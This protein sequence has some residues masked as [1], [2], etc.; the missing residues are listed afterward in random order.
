M[1]LRT[2]NM[3]SDK[4]FVLAK[5]EKVLIPHHH[6]LAPLSS[7]SPVYWTPPMA[8]ARPQIS[9]CTNFITPRPPAPHPF[10]LPMTPLSLGCHP[11]ICLPK[12][13]ACVE[14]GFLGDGYSLAGVGDWWVHHIGTNTVLA[15]EVPQEEDEN[16]TS[17]FNEGII[18]S[19]PFPQTLPS[20]RE[21]LPYNARCQGI[22]RPSYFK[23]AGMFCIYSDVYEMWLKH[24]CMEHSF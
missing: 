18:T 5:K 11:S 2:P 3:T 16:P 19:L 9:Y 14:L 1:G 17:N 24:T 20:H 13:R 21:S 6:L 22:R 4:L 23:Y 10:H 12:Y 7:F 15:S 8:I